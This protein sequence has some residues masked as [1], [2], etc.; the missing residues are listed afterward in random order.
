MGKR[1]Q[2]RVLAHDY[3]LNIGMLNWFR[4]HGITP[5]IKVNRHTVAA[6]RNGA[7]IDFLAGEASHLI[8]M[9]NG[10]WPDESSDVILQ[11]DQDAV[12]LGHVATGGHIGHV[13]D[14]EL[15]CACVRLSRAC[16]EAI[17][18]PWFGFEFDKT[19]SQSIKCDCM[20]LRDKL[21]A[22]GFKTYMV[23]VIAHRVEML[24]LPSEDGTSMV[25]KS[26]NDFLHCK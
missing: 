3:Q 11:G 10:A 5:D 24:A 13:G 9:E 20:M 18:P 14:G 2:F 16:L 1:I 8:L 25:I 12:Y 26:K 15:G 23:G 19:G 22:A 7:V 17:E 6:A 4:R 21:H